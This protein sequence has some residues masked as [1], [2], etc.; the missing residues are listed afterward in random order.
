[1]SEFRHVEPLWAENVPVLKGYGDRF[2][3]NFFHANMCSF[4]TRKEWMLTEAP[5][6]KSADKNCTISKMFWMAK[7]N[8]T[9][10][11][12]MLCDLVEQS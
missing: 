1:M 8:G 6:M 3:N 11:I 7:Q 9:S 5:Q 10:S 2:E 4:Y 12:V